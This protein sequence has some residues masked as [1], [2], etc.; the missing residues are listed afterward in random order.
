M[1]S[2]FALLVLA[3]VVPPGMEAQ[4]PELAVGARVRVTSPRHHFNRD[5]ATVT[6]LRGDSI[7]LMSKMGTRAVALSNVTALEVSMG[8]RNQVMRNGLIGLGV[9]ALAGLATGLAA[10]DECRDTLVCVAPAGAGEFMAVGALAFGGAGFV[11][12]AITGLFT[13]SDRWAPAT[14]PARATVGITRTGASIGFTRAF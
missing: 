7:V 2:L 8:T 3:L 10:E 4:A 5:V 1:K 9:G 11:V 14:P 6:E 13:R 12:G